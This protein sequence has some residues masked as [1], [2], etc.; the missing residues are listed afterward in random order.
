MTL[1]LEKKI[2]IETIKMMRTMTYPTENK[3]S[4]TRIK[5]FLQSK[6]DK[7]KYIQSFIYFIEIRRWLLS[8]ILVK[9]QR[10]NKF[11]KIK[12]PDSQITT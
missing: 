1:C 2:I 6:N 5:Y 4:L 7:N 12:Y 11:I 10:K 9:E 3:S 8:W